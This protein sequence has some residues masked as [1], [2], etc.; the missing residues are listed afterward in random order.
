MEK[1]RI[2]AKAIL[3]A[4]M[5]FKELRWN[6]VSN[7]IRASGTRESLVHEQPICFDHRACSQ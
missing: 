6:F 5:K 7:W 4:F 1:W 2:T 3:I